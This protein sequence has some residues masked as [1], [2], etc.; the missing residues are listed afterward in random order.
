M[1]QEYWLP[2]LVYVAEMSV[3]TIGTIRIIFVSRGKK[4]FASLLGFFEVTIWLFAIGKIMQNLDSTPCFLAFAAGFMSGNFLGM[5]IEEKLAIGNRLVRVITNHDPAGLI[6]ALK[7][8]HFG[9]TAIDGVG[10]TGPVRIILT[11]VRRKEVG[12]VVDMIQSFDRQAFY[13]V[14]DLQTA[15]RGVFPAAKPTYGMTPN[16]RLAPRAASWL[17]VAAVSLARMVRV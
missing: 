2:L 14:D 10:A 1:S 9:V 15:T 17:A 7:L 13:S 4:L 16:S 5:T 3:V 8:A 11:V 6:A 12:R